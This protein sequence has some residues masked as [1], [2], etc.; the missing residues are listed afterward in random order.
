MNEQICRLVDIDGDML[1]NFLHQIVLHRPYFFLPGLQFCFLSLITP[2]EFTFLDASSHL[3]MRVCPSV[4]PSVSIKEKTPKSTK[5]STG[6]G[7]G[8]TREGA[9]MDNG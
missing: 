1:Q 4:G 3:Y 7:K 9:I 5:I 2:K 6:A 8:V